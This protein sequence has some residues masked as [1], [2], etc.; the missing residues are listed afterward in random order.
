MTREQAIYMLKGM[1]SVYDFYTRDRFEAL[2]M[3]I[4]ALEQE[5]CTD[6]ISRQ[7]VLEALRTMYYTHIIKTEDGD[8]YIDYND[9]VYEVE[10]LS[11]VNP[12][13]KVGQW[14]N[15]DDKCP[16]CGKSKFEGLD[17]DIWA[18]WQPKYC[19]NCGAKMQEVKE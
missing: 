15:G 1:R 10:Q 9:T 5:H 12:A 2:S 3:A 18:D 14:V 16:C 4:E 13:E 19:P 17:A 7:A 11:P 6:A 8:E